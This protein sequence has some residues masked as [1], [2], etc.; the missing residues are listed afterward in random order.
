MIDKQ[1]IIVEHYPYTGPWKI[2]AEVK[3]QSFVNDDPNEPGALPPVIAILQ[4]EL[5]KEIRVDIYDCHDLK[6]T[7]T[8]GGLESSDKKRAKWFRN[9]YTRN[10]GHNL[11]EVTVR[12]TI[13]IGVSALTMNRL[14]CFFFWHKWWHP[15]VAID[16]TC[17]RCW[18]RKRF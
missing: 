11:R 8:N 2:L 16:S 6:F 14:F 13:K 1:I 5:T 10:K 4:N 18:K 12:F 3:D 15:P 9:V 17:F 7:F